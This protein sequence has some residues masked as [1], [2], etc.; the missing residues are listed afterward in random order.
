[1]SEVFVGVDVGTGSARAGLFDARGGLIASARRPIAVWRRPGRVVEQSSRDIWQATCAAV[2]EALAAG[3]VAPERVAGVGF[4]AT[5]SLV[6]RD[7]GGGPLPA[8]PGGDS[9]CDTIVWMDHRAR[10]EADSINALGHPVLGYFGGRLSPEMQPPKLLWLARHA[11]EVFA[12]AG[13]FFDLADYL[14]YCATG[15]LARSLC[16]VA[17][18]WAYL[19]H[20]RRWPRDFFESVGLGALAQDDFARIGNEIVAPGSTLGAGLTAEAAKAMGLCPGTPVAA[21]LVD[22]HAGALGTLGALEPARRRAALVLGTSSCCMTLAEEARF[23]PNLWGPSYSVLLPGQWLTEGGHSAFGAAMERLMRLHPAFR[24]DEAG[25]AFINLER[26]IERRAGGLSAAARLADGLHVLP[27]FLGNRA[28]RADAT[29]RA[30]IFGLDLD[31]GEESLHSLYVAGLCGL[32][33]GLAEIVDALEA[34]G[35]RIEALFVSGGASRSPLVRQ[36]LAD[37]TGRRLV[38]ADSAEP[39]LLGSAMLGAVAAGRWTLSQ[40]MAE[41]SRAGEGIAPAPEMAGLHA[42]RRAAFAALI[43]AERAVREAMREPAEP[44]DWPQLVIFDCDGVLVDSEPIALARTREALAAAGVDFTEA[45]MR[46]RFL[47]VSAHIVEAA[48]AEAL[49]EPL[50]VDFQRRVSAAILASFERELQGVASVREAVEALAA[51]VCVASSSAYERIRASLRIV[52][53]DKLFEPNIF[54]AS[55]VANG[56]PAPDLFLYAARRMGV[57]PSGCVVVEDS[58]PGVTAARRAGAFVLGFV[59]GAHARSASYAQALRDAGAEDI[60]SDMREL[61]HLISREARRR[62]TGTP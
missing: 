62:A 25:E 40:A 23:L 59:G 41:M 60:F 56:K 2:R 24:A 12:A 43:S 11:P 51:P 9:D 47:G 18:K 53:Y 32:G 39:V 10:A 16:T 50:P 42:R 45:E 52:G 13:H 27:D 5:C 8:S 1:M 48:A 20:E 14:T 33:Q 7:R 17:C 22:A 38:A 4:D 19:A 49:G 34:G 36:I 29:A 58:V 35:P 44:G 28:P 6:L 21:G 61:P 37:A 15:S 46:A 26:A 31:E 54:S 55:E 3:D 30:A 57:A